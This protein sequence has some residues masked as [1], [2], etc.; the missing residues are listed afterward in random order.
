MPAP[1]TASA[2]SVLA[3]TNN[4]IIEADGGVLTL[5]GS[6]NNSSSG[7]IA[8]ATGNK[9]LLL[10]GTFTNAGIVNLAGGTFDTN[11]A[12]VN[13]TGQITGYGNPHRR[14]D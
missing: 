6:V 1:W 5:A 2:M 14:T 9:V 11:G 3:I 4:G 10:G 7:L 13:N 12:T 8:A